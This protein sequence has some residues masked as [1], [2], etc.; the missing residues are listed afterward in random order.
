[1]GLKI[2]S[3]LVAARK[4]FSFARK[5]RLPSSSQQH[6]RQ[7]K[8]SN[9]TKFHTLALSQLQSAPPDS[10]QA[11]WRPRVWRNTIEKVSV[12]PV[13]TLHSKER[14]DYLTGLFLAAR[15][16]WQILF[17]CSTYSS[18]SAFSVIPSLRARRRYLE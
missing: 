16:S 12:S 10:I 4:E 11:S 7:R 6:T 18:M 8:N 17:C 14:L 5:R 15:V 13:K 3:V 2:Y 1:M 9:H